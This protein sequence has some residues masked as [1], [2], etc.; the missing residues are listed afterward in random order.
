MT[1]L[2]RYGGRR[3]SSLA[4]TGNESGTGLVFPCRS[5][6]TYSM[7]SVNQWVMPPSSN[8][9]NTKIP[10]PDQGA[11]PK[12][13]PA[14]GSDSLGLAVT[15]YVHRLALENVRYA[16]QGLLDRAHHAAAWLAA[17][18][19]A[20]GR[21]N[22][23]KCKRHQTR[24]STPHSRPNRRPGFSAS[25]DRRGHFALSPPEDRTREQGPNW[26]FGANE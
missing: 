9:T 15:I 21:F 6:D 16:Q 26:D 13:T 17:S 12:P 7:L 23:R 8:R 5:P 25:D 14:V 11:Y 22:K 24:H 2:Q 10:S 20:S 18:L 19:A 3:A 4:T 1:Q